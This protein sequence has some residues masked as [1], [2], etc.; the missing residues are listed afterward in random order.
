MSTAKNTKNS[1]R[2]EAPNGVFLFEI[3]AFFEVEKG[4]Y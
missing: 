1:K 4:F 3:S 2:A